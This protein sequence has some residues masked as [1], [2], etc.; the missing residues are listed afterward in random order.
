[1]FSSVIFLYY[2][3]CIN[4]L[5]IQ[6]L[7]SEIINRPFLLFSLQVSEVSIFLCR[8]SNFVFTISSSTG[9][10]LFRKHRW[11]REKKT[12]R[13]LENRISVNDSCLS[14]RNA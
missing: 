13:T 4:V 10:T 7:I 6:M 5:I 9:L 1:M 2:Y 14:T 12:R 11:V 8:V 3:T